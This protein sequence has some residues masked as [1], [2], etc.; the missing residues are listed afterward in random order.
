MSDRTLDQHLSKE[1]K[2]MRKIVAK[3][4]EYVATYSQQTSYDMYSDKTFLDD[5]LYGIGLALQIGSAKDN[6]G[7]G[8]YERFKQELREHLK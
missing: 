8:G 5:M 3:M 6:T 7:A 4:Q 1:Q 2:R